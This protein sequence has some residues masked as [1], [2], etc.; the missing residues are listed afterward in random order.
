MIYL[1]MDLGVKYYQGNYSPITNCIKANG[2]SNAWLHHKGRNKHHYE[3]WYDEE[4]TPQCIVM[5]YKYFVEMVCDTLSAG[6]T[7]EGK[8]WTKEFQIGYYM[9]KREHITINEKMDKALIEVY[10]DTYYGLR[11]VDIKE[12]VYKA[13]LLGLNIEGEIQNKINHKS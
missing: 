2:H 8:S 11:N 7:Y 1:N 3:Y 10:E 6:M 9:K 4:A 12:N 5:P 13:N